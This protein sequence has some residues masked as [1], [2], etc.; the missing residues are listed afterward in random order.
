MSEVNV[1]LKETEDSTKE[2]LTPEEMAG[3]ERAQKMGRVA[4]E[5][6]PFR[7]PTE[8][9]PLPLLAWSTHPPRHYTM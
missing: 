1:D 5:T 4:N 3:I 2:V 8:F 9:V 7:I 6:S